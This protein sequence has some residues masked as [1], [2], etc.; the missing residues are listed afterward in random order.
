MEEWEDWNESDKFW[1]NRD[2][3]KPPKIYLQIHPLIRI[4]LQFKKGSALV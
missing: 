1:K 3:L 4:P 2:I